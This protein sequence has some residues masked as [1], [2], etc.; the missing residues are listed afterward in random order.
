MT[1][2]STP[3]ETGI[4]ASRWRCL[5]VGA[6][7]T[8]RRHLEDALLA[9]LIALPVMFAIALL[10]GLASE[11]LMGPSEAARTVDLTG[12]ASLGAVLVLGAF[13]LLARGLVIA[14]R[15]PLMARALTAAVRAGTPAAHVPAP[16]QWQQAHERS[17]TTYRHTAI[18]LLAILGLFSLAAVYA[19]FHEPFL[20][21]LAIIVGCVAVLAVIAAG[22]PLTGTVLRRRQLA[23]LEP[24]DAHWTQA[25]RIIAAGHVLTSESVAA[26]RGGRADRDVPG[27]AARSLGKVATTVVGA[28]GTAAYLGLQTMA[29]VAYPDRERWSG[30]QLGDRAQL[31][32]QAERLVDLAVTVWVVGGGL[33]VLGLVTGALAALVERTQEHAAL[34]RALEEGGAPPPYPLL[35]RYLR[36]SP[37]PLLRA[38]SALVGAVMVAGV[39]LLILHRVVDAPSWEY[40]AGAGQ[41]L[42]EAAA[43]GPLILVLAVV[44]GA[45]EVALAS[46]LDGRDR[47]L[48][49]AVVQQWPVQPASGG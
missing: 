9:G 8:V 6:L 39:T 43:F 3:A 17:D 11:E 28:G 42:R 45:L 22:I 4:A 34:R 20:T 46:L 7:E 18:A 35:Q 2:P 1:M 37:P 27:T 48:R 30:G 41:G 13:G 49:D 23:L 32:P 16:L 38:V 31:D 12:R 25:H 44:V 29:A 21:G 47:R 10:G 26:A 36:H 19:A 14:L 5:P 40:Y 24:V 33:A 15:G